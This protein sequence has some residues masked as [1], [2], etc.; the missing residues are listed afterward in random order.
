MDISMSDRGR[1]LF[2]VEEP[3]GSIDSVNHAARQGS[4]PAGLVVDDVVV[5][6]GDD[7]V[8]AFT[9]RSNRQLIRHGS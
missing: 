9:H 1:D 4:R 8:A 5:V 7:L 3:A 2:R 6:M